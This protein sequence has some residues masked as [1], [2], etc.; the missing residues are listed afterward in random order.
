[1]IKVLIY[2]FFIFCI[3]SCNTKSVEQNTEKLEINAADSTIVNTNEQE[4][5]NDGAI[6][7]HLDFSLLHDTILQGLEIYYPIVMKQDYIQNKSNHIMILTQ[8]S[9]DLNKD[10]LVEEHSHVVAFGFNLSPE[11]IKQVWKLQD[12]LKEQKASGDLESNIYWQ[13]QYCA[14][15]DSDKDGNDEIYLVYSSEGN[16]SISDGRL[17]IFVIYNGKK[18]HIKHQNGVLDF[19]RFTVVDSAFKN[20]PKSVMNKFFTIME[21][22]EKNELSI[23]PYGWKE[24]ISSGATKVEE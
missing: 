11:G 10:G 19:E 12:M 21:D 18:Y 4:N 20:L 6:Q 1:M 3:L 5:N 7:Q 17:N 15:E 16:N 13:K 23:F 22:I 9:D 8:N 14:A 2:Y 24:K